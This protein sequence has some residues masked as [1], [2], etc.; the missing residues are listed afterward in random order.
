LIEF[1]FPFTSNHSVW[2]KPDEMFSNIIDEIKQIRDKINQKWEIDFPDR[3]YTNYLKPLLPGQINPDIIN[4]NFPCPTPD[5][6]KRLA[7]IEEIL[8]IDQTHQQGLLFIEAPQFINEHK[9]C[10]PVV[11]E[12]IESYG[13]TYLPLLDNQTQPLL[14]FGDKQ[15]MSQFGALIASVTTAEFLA[16]KLDIPIKPEALAYYKN[17]FF[18]DYTLD[19]EGKK[20]TLTLIP[21]DETS[22]PNLNFMWEIFSNNTSIFKSSEMGANMLEYTFSESKRDYYIQVMINNPADDYYLRGGFTISIP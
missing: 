22:I 14:W 16:E 6:P 2:K 19:V 3:G 4:S 1:L 7:T 17:F 20:V 5:L 13:V 9:N 15:H 10:R 12:L 21:F 11:Q 8:G 18:K